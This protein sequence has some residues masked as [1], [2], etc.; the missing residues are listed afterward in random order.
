MSIEIKGITKL[1]GKQKALDN[2]SFLLNKGELTGFL[3][4]NGAG[5][6]TLMKIIT[7]Y[8]LPDD[9]EVFVNGIKNEPDKIELRKEIGYLP[10][11]NPLYTDLYV[12]EYLEIAAGFY[13]LRNI[14][15]KISE[16]IDL[17]GLGN[18]RHK[19][20]GALSK[21]YRQRVGLAQALLHN[22]SV[23][24]LDEPTTGLDPNQLDEI[25]TLIRN[26]SKEKTVLLSSHIMQEVEAVCSRIVV[27]NQ[28]EIV[29]DGP[30]S[31]LKQT[32]KNRQIVVVQFDKPVDK[33]LIYNIN[34]VGSAT[35][36]ENV[37]ELESLGEIDIRPEIFRFAVA[38]NLVLLAMQEKQ[39][40]L[41]NIFHELTR[42][43]SVS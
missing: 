15:A 21:G 14:R 40:N 17:V 18:E 22:P 37:W 2:V 35:N 31:T 13:Q 20:I 29:A 27:I 11:H 34:G 16:I 39:K 24:I 38:S 19:K 5:K 1:Y 6:S 42:G 26:V 28:G 23:L 9:G 3:G 7:G 4:P 25:R 12:T 43:G 32:N 33:Q 30:I 10:E 8:V 41:E 36:Y